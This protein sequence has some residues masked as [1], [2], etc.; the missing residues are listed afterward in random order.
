[1]GLAFVTV[2]AGQPARLVHAV[3]GAQRAAGDLP[4]LLEVEGG[5]VGDLVPAVPAHDAVPAVAEGGDHREDV[6]GAVDGQYALRLLG[7]ADVGQEQGLDHGDAGEG[8]ADRLPHG[9]AVA[10]GA[11]DVG[12]SAGGG[13]SV[14]VPHGH[15]HAGAVL[16][17]GEDFGLVVEGD[18]EIPGALL[19]QIGRA[20]CRE[21]V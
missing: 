9:A 7:Q 10:V 5:V 15:V 8:L 2:E 19:Q 17:E 4:H 20:S 18:A 14:R 6:A 21:R 11:D 16:P 1:R 12:G 13:R 3:V